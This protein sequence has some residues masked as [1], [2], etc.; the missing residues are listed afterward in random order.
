MKIKSLYAL[1]LRLLFSVCIA[2]PADI[3]GAPQASGSRAGEVTRVIPEV[4]IARGLKTMTASAKSVVN[5]EDLVNTQINGRARIALDDGS[6][7]NLG[8]QSSMHVVKHDAATQQTDL[9]LIYGKLRTQAQK[10][11]KPNGKFEVRTPAGVAGI[12]GTDFY[13][14]YDSSS[15]SVV[16]FEGVVRLCN[17]AG[18]C[19]QVRA[20]QMSSVRTADNSGSPRPL[21]PQPTALDIMTQAVQSTNV[22]ESSGVVVDAKDA[23]V[24][25]SSLTRG[26]SLFTG[27]VVSTKSNGHAQLRV[28]QSRFE[29]IGESSGA[30]FPGLNGAV[31]ELRQGTLIAALNSPSET[32]EIFASDARI[33][34]RSERPIL[35]QI[36]MKSSCNLRIKVQHGS[37]DATVGKETKTLEEGHSYDV[38]TEVSLSYSHKPAVSPDESEYHRG[39]QHTACGLAAQRRPIPPGSSHFKILV[40]AGVAA[41]IIIPILFLRGGGEP[42]P[43]SPSLP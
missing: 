41:A 34:P 30:F 39:H 7:L 22:A 13:V 36:T 6:V 15:M 10:I 33:V 18:V 3:V 17:L 14:G 2:T 43:E 8:S 32:F 31:A 26:A 21:V 40:G 27:D 37:L 19:V 24:G 5:W 16:V 11:A 28:R 20:G 1:A 9:E 42:P 23:Q 35:A 38:T 12:V 25:E 29:L 4:S